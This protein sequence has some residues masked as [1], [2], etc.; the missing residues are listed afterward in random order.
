MQLPQRKILDHLTPFWVKGTP[1]FFVTICASRR[2]ANSLCNPETSKVIFEATKHYQGQLRWYTHLL[3]LMPDHLHALISFPKV[4]SMHQ[5]VRAWKH[6]LSKQHGIEWQ[7]DYF[8][9]RLRSDESHE[10]KAAYIRLNPVRAG[11]TASPEQWSYVWEPG[12]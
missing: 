12:R 6:Y 2:G 9:H 10:E 8:D 4:E 11:L 7:R 1:I 3:L 5:V